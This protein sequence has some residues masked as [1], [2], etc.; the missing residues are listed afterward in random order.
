MK[1]QLG[2]RKEFLLIECWADKKIASLT[3]ME[4][5]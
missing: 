3:E 2:T 1:H 4:V 5:G